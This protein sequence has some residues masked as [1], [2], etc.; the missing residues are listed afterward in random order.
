MRRQGVYHRSSGTLP[1]QRSAILAP[2]REDSAIASMTRIVSRACAAVSS[3]WASDR[4]WR[5]RLAPGVRA[6]ANAANSFAGS[7]RL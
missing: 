2:R 3:P 1:D 5:Q 7:G 6:A 4:A